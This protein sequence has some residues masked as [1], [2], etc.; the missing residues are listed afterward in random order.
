MTTN[1]V[2]TIGGATR[3]IMFYTDEAL[4]LDNKEDLLRQKLIAVEYGAKIYSQDVFFTYGGGGANTAVNFA[5]L[6]IKTQTILS[7]GDDFVGQNIIKYLK[8]KKINTNLIQ[9][10]PQLKTA[11]SF[12]VNVGQYKEHVIFVYRG[13]NDALRLNNQLIRKINTPWVYLASPSFKMMGDFK[14]LF[15][16]CRRKKIKVVWNPGADQLKL[17]LKKLAK[18]MKQTVVFDVNRDE[19]LELLVSLKKDKV[20][21]SVNYILKNLHQYGQKLTVVT[22]GHR[23][24]YIYDGQKIYF[25]PASKRK[26][27][28][29]T[30]AGDVFGSS[31]VAGLIKYHWD[32]EKALKLAIINSTAVIMKI[33]A[34]EGLLTQK[35]L[36]K[37]KL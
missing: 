27:I 14:K 25:R 36:K 12:I 17:G 28:N 21:N 24:A 13:A 11:T 19:A 22:D 32:L 37:Y 5:S 34:Q 33:G 23:G 16:H 26:G 35:D 1:K 7:V 15:D 18:F 31:L 20:K 3:D 4:L 29:T 8:S 9:K 10:H 2:T 6:G 30:G